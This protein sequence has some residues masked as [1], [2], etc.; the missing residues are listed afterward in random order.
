MDYENN[1]KKQDNLVK[2]CSH[3]V[4]ILMGKGVGSFKE[5]FPPTIALIENAHKLK[6]IINRNILIAIFTDFP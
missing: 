5:I 3:W 6:K 4:Y 2:Y 1:N